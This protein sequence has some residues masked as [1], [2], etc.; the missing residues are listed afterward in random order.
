MPMQEKTDVNR[1]KK[2]RA[3]SGVSSSLLPPKED[4]PDELD[5]E[6]DD[7]LKFWP[8]PP[9]AHAGLER[10]SRNV[11]TSGCLRGGNKCLPV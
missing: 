3:I 6:L 10:S 1:Q 5:D 9:R 7:E 8:P 4:P 2:P 11:E